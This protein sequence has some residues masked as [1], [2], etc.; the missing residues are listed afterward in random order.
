ML[1]GGDVAAKTDR[2]HAI[3]D[4]EVDVDNIG[5]GAQGAHVG[6]DVEESV[7]TAIGRFP[8][9][10]QPADRI[11]LGQVEGDGRCRTARRDDAFGG[12]LRGFFGDVTYDHP[13]ALG[14]E[15]NRGGRSQP[16]GAAYDDDDLVGQSA[17]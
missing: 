9:P 5:V 1:H 14:P 4:V 13:A 12:P 17:Q 11:G 2:H 16:G 15:A 6:T 7:D 8:G 10:D 3:P